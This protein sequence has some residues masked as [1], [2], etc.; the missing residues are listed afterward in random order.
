MMLKLQLKLRAALSQWM[1]QVRKVFKIIFNAPVYNSLLRNA[2]RGFINSQLELA[3]FYLDEK[4][5]MIEA[6]AWASVACYRGHTEAG[7]VKRKAE[8]LLKPE[9]VKLAWDK[10]RA[11][12]RQF[13]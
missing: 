11:Y 10:A 8:P 12:Q 7:A 3:R 13:I 5:D 9:Q 1:N 4:Q 6:Y 2:S